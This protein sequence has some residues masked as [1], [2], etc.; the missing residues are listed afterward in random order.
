MNRDDLKRYIGMT[1]YNLGQVEKDYFQHI[2]LGALS[3][4][5]AG[6]LV[7]KGG[8]ALQKTGVTKRFSEDLDFT[9]GAPASLDSLKDTAAG[10][11]RNYNYPVRAANFEESER[12]VS[13]RLK[14]EGPLFR[15][16]RGA[17]TVRVEASRRE[18][19]FLEPDRREFTPPYSDILPYIFDVMHPDE[20]L[21]EKCRA[22]LTRQ[23]ARDLFDL[24]R[25]LERGARL[26]RAL[27]DSKLEYYGMSFDLGVFS[28][29]CDRLGPGWERE[30][31]ALMQNPPS[32]DAV[33][34]AV[35]K[36]L[37]HKKK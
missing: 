1:G 22:I 35:M 30:L 24:H 5:G 20:M 14:I 7:F 32:F 4:S 34:T 15:N 31:G 10:T 16:G 27:V 17:C 33:S 19:V 6:S 13:F 3:R 11:I 23:K 37:R 12:S 28:D 26:D 36:A 18:K 21:A 29:K 2:I 9:M 25:L 8:T